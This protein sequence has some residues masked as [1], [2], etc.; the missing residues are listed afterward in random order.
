MSPILLSVDLL[1]EYYDTSA[2]RLLLERRQTRILSP[3]P[4]VRCAGE[5]EQ[6]GATDVGGTDSVCAI[7]FHK[8]DPT[9]RAR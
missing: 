1:T 8:L 5:S 9:A 4:S 3:T 6:G 2:V 7:T